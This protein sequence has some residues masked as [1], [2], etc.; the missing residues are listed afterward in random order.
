MDLPNENVSIS[1][2]NSAEVG[3]SNSVRKINIVI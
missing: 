2:E 3:L 1:E